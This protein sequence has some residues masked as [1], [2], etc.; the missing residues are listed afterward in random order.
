MIDSIFFFFFFLHNNFKNRILFLFHLLNRSIFPSFFRISS[1]I[2]SSIFETRVSPLI[3]SVPIRPIA[4]INF[5]KNKPIMIEVNEPRKARSS[6]RILFSLFS[7]RSQFQVALHAIIRA[8]VS[9]KRK[10]SRWIFEY[11]FFNSNRLEKRRDSF[12]EDM[13][14]ASRVK[15]KRGSGLWRKGTKRVD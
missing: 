5:L 3:Y 10:P 13:L 15:V 7:P 11:S 12:G 4:G 2:F 9:S 6:S 14:F 1:D 8:P